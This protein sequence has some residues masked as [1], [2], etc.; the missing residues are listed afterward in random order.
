MRADAVQV[1]AESRSAG[2]II[3]LHPVAPT[4]VGK[5]PGMEKQISEVDIGESGP[6]TLSG[7]KLASCGQAF[8]SETGLI[9]SFA[10]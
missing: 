4:L 1:A 10:I 2:P 9:P 6:S 7:S 5:L 8:E 3:N